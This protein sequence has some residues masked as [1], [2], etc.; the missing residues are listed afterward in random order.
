[1]LIPL[2]NKVLTGN[3]VEMKKVRVG[4][5]VALEKVNSKEVFQGT[6]VQ[7]RK[8]N[9]YMLYINVTTYFKEGRHRPRWQTKVKGFRNSSK[10]RIHLVTD[11]VD[12]R[13]QQA[14]ARKAYAKHRT[15]LGNRRDEAN[16]SI[17]LLQQQAGDKLDITVD[18]RM[19][20]V[21]MKKLY[22]AIAFDFHPDRLQQVSESKQQFGVKMMDAISIFRN[23]RAKV[24]Q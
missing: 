24:V 14:K 11:P 18:L 3:T 22:R 8:P 13:N 12:Q 6:V 1:M 17:S 5:E 15:L 21:D 4:Y 19:N 2:D 9:Q 7:L 16:E 23:M 20:D 10:I